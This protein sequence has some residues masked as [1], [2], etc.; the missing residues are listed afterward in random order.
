M[1]VLAIIPARGGSK[2]VVDKNIHDFCGKPLIAHTIDCAKNSK[3]V[4]RVI[5][6]TDSEKIAD[7]AKAH[8]AEVPFLRPSELAQDK[9]KIVD[10]IVH[11]VLKL[12]EEEGYFPD[13]I[14]LLQTTSPL[15]LSSDIDNALDLCIKR[16][17]D[18]VVSLCQTE[19]LLYT[20]DENDRLHLVSSEDRKSVV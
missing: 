17:A 4:N 5:V 15:R 12:K 20:K 1:N 7:I 10:A 19:Q 2:G 9:S 13:Y 3:Y 14:L 8:G 11:T 6:S 18:A 16:D